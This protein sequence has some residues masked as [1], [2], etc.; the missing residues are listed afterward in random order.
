[1]PRG[2]F[3][4]FPRGGR[5]RASAASA[6][7]VEEQQI[8]A[9]ELTREIDK[10][11]SLLESFSILVPSG[12]E[13][14]DGYCSKSLKSKFKSIGDEQRNPFLQLMGNVLSADSHGRVTVSARETRG[15]S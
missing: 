10:T 2:F 3:G 4:F 1:M 5:E 11:G 6:Y 12:I 15:H 8:Q 14:S 13:E 9:D 7:Q